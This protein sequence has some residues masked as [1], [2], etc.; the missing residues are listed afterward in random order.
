M[1]NSNDNIQELTNR[2][3]KIDRDNNWMNTNQYTF[4]LTKTE[5]AS[6]TTKITNIQHSNQISTQTAP[7]KQFS[8]EKFVWIIEE[9]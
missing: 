4:T 2:K 3:F 6:F 9:T 1:D 5:P 8:Y 7:A